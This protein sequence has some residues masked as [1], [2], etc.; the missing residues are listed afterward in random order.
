MNGLRPRSRVFLTLIVGLYLIVAT[1]YTLATPVLEASDEFKHY[2][3]VQYVQT[4]H[5]LPVL[6]PPTC[7]ETPSECPWLQDGGQ[8]PIYYILLAASTS[9]SDTSRGTSK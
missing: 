7:L 5:D 9:W 8:P 2:P 6:D 1:S 4:H 3:Y